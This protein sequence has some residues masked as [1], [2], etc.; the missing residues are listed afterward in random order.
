MRAGPMGE[1]HTLQY[2]ER[3]HGSGN[4]SRKKFWGPCVGVGGIL[5]EDNTMSN[6]KRGSLEAGLSLTGDSML[7]RVSH[8]ETN[9][10]SADKL[11]KG[12]AHRKRKS[13]FFPSVL[14]PADCCLVPLLLI[15]RV[16]IVVN[17]LQGG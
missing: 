6:K 1:P 4:P 13:L 9:V 10:A 8:N 15:F 16:T 7:A 14:Y 2:S 12:Q 3:A 17:T 11:Y 5:L